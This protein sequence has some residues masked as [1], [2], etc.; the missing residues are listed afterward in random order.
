MTKLPSRQEIIE[1]AKQ[2]ATPI[3]FTKLEEAGI[4]EKKGAWFKIKN[5]KNL[6]EYASRQV[7]SIKTDSRGNCYVQFPKSWKR[8]QVLYRRMT[9]KAYNK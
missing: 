6:P 2:L 4:I 7:R 8:A 1:L 5:L 3:D 9:G